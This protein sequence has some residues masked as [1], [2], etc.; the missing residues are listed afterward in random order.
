MFYTKHTKIDFNISAVNE[1]KLRVDDT[2][3]KT[4]LLWYPNIF[5]HVIPQALV[6]GV[7]LGLFAGIAGGSVDFAESPQGFIYGAL[8]AGII[9]NGAWNSW[10]TA[11][12]F[13][14]GQWITIP[15]K[16]D[17]AWEIVL[18]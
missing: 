15:L 6:G 17:D 5:L 1:I 3:I 18:N 16:G 2:Y 12:K 9:I 14:K 7:V 11:A 10:P 4:L 13:G 8:A